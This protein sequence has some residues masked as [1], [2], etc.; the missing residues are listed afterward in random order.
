MAKSEGRTVISGANTPQT[1]GA[2]W[3]THSLD[4]SPS[5]REVRFEVHARPRHRVILDPELYSQLE[6]EARIRGISSETLA[7]RWLTERISSTT[8]RSGGGAR[9]DQPRQ[10]PNKRIQPTRKKRVRG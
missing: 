2:Y 6:R 9:R 10:P 8:R 7:N 5:V 1:I 4:S 3:D